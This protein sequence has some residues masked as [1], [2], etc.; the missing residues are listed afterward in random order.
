M[1]RKYVGKKKTYR[2][3][4]KTY[5]SF[6]SWC[7]RRGLDVSTAIRGSIGLL[8]KKG[9]VEELLKDSEMRTAAIEL[10]IKN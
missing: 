5:K 8:M 9:S 3:D 1:S 4:N 7:S 2:V 6:Q 10:L